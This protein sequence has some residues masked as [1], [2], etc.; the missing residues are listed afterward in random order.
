LRSIAREVAP[1]TAQEA[2]QSPM[3]A[4]LSVEK[5]GTR[6]LFDGCSKACF[7]RKFSPTAKVCKGDVK[8]Q[9]NPCILCASCESVFLTRCAAGVTDPED[10]RVSEVSLPTIHALQ[11]EASKGVALDATR[12]VAGLSAGQEAAGQAGRQ[13]E[14]LRRPSDNRPKRRRDLLE[15]GRLRGADDAGLDGAIRRSRGAQAQA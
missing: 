3:L 5:D 8:R 13:P 7:G 9:Q 1:S 12:H 10:L 2:T 11:V 4:D 14:H 6:R 15:A